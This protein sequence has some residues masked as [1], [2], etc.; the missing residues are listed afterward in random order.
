MTRVSIL[1]AALLLSVSVAAQRMDSLQV[2]LV[3]ISADRIEPVVGSKTTQIDSSLIESFANAR[4]SDLLRLNGMVGIRSYGPS[5]SSNLSIRGTGPQHSLLLWNGMPLTDGMLGQSDVSLIP[6]AAVGSL[7]VHHGPGSLEYQPGGLG[8]AVEL[9][10]TF[11]ADTGISVSVLG[12]YGSFQNYSGQL[13]L[14][15]FKGR[16]KSATSLS[17]Q[18]GKNE[19]PYVNI[20]TLEERIDVTTNSALTNYGASHSSKVDLGKGHELS[21]HALGTFSDRR[22][23]PTMLTYDAD[24]SQSDLD[25]LGAAE[26]KWMGNGTELSWNVNHLYSHQQYSF[27]DSTYRFHHFHQMTRSMMRLKHQIAPDLTI[28]GGLDVN[29]ETARSDSAYRGQVRQRHSESAFLSLRHQPKKWIGYQILIREDLV[30][31][32]ASPFQW[33][34][35]L[36]VIPVKSLTLKA[37][38]S[39]N[40]RPPSLNELYWFPYGN[41]DLNSETGLSY[42]VGATYRILRTKFQLSTEVTWFDSWVNNWVV[43]I[44]NSDGLYSPE[45]KKQVRARGIE[46]SVSASG[47]LGKVKLGGGLNYTFNRS[48]IEKS[49]EGD[50]A[51]GNQLLY[52]PEHSVN[53]NLQVHWKYLSFIYGQTLISERPT[54]AENDRTLPTYTLGWISATAK[55]PIKK[56]GIHLGIRLDN[57]WNT[58]YQLIAWRPMPGINYQLTLKYQFS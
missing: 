6:N 14:K 16:W 58:Q 47:K 35:G 53:M 8:G 32:K 52:V 48:T 10:T 19:F 1:M 23:P 38:F 26:W 22:L 2:P 49:F 11:L 30:A 18:S 28:K 25:I 17:Y 51:I 39:R 54:T 42:E 29:L 3:S 27:S 4:L 44:P 43:W 55:L 12:G 40:F 36:N 33:S 31:S 34:V 46:A 13:G 5:G 57:I 41:P 15:H 21:I 45:N 20:A 7:S 37:N 24:A 56:H 50:Q 9:G